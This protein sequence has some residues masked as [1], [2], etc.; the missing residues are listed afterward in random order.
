LDFPN[1]LHQ[2]LRILAGIAIVAGILALT[3]RAD[4]SADQGDL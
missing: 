1:V 2:D 4:A 3:L